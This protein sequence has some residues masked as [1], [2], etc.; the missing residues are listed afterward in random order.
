MQSN[1]HLRNPGSKC[2]TIN[3]VPV[4][5]LLFSVPYVN[6][7]CSTRLRHVLE[8]AEDGCSVEATLQDFKEDRRGFRSFMFRQ[9]NIGRKTFEELEKLVDQALNLNLGNEHFTLEG[10]SAGSEQVQSAANKALQLPFYESLR[11]TDLSVRLTNVLAAIEKPSE[12]HQT[13]RDFLENRDQFRDFII[14]QPN[15]GRRSMV[16]LETKI[17]KILAEEASRASTR[18][19]VK[20]GQPSS[21]A[22]IEMPQ[23]EINTPEDLALQLLG[24]LSERDRQIV[25]RRYGIGV[26]FPETLEQIATSFGVTR[27]RIRQIEQKALR[28][29]SHG[30]NAR[31]L[32][33]SL[34]THSDL[35][36]D[37]L[38]QGTG[39]LI[40]GELMPA[41][42][43]YGFQHINGN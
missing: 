18:V 41:R 3:L 31:L 33:E 10:S 37:V 20:N 16:E 1:R 32:R 42:L 17:N 40:S 7:R 23:S 5:N 4:S 28:R 13:I 34:V 21:L 30:N 29:L 15:M 22:A 35:V 26:N 19:T 8:A 39:A 12:S 6:L 43:R 36:W 9:P 24:K 14:K 11:Q 25:S 2:K 27:E 38:S